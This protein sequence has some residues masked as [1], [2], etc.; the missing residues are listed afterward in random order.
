M[1]LNPPKTLFYFQFNSVRQ[2]APHR[3]AIKELIAPLGERDGGRF[4]VALNEGV[5]N[6]LI[7]GYKNGPEDLVKL[8]I[9]DKGPKIC[10]HIRCSGRGFTHDLKID[11]SLFDDWIRESGRGMQIILHMVD[12]VSIEDGGRVV[13]LCMRKGDSDPLA[14]VE[15]A[16]EADWERGE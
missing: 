3:K 1:K 2:F 10:A 5:N 8:T 9:F 6:A 4:F 14:R 16:A 11:E 13:K 12:E 7:H 15:M